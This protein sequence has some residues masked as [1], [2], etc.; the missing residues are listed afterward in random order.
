MFPQISVN[1]VA[2]IVAVIVSFVVG[3][4]WHT[5]LFGKLWGRL[6]NI[7]E[8]PMPPLS[9]MLGSIALNLVSTFLIAF[10]MVHS[11]EIWRPSTW[12][13]ARADEGFYFYG[14]NGAFFNCL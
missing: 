14:F 6:N 7:P 8:G 12:Q 11:L 2:I 9:S 10:V 5:V 4:I 3:F 13:I 1:F